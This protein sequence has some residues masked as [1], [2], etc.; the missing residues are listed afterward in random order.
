MLVEFDAYLPQPKG[1]LTDDDVVGVGR[2]ERSAQP[3]LWGQLQSD[4]GQ[5][6][7]ST[8]RTEGVLRTGRARPLAGALV[9]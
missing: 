5:Y 1:D 4:N 3:L 9:W 7:K 2:T 6:V 8:P